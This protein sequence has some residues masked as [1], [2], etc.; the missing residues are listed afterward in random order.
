MKNVFDIV[1]LVTLLALAAAVLRAAGKVPAGALA[2]L[3]TL[4]Q[5]LDLVALPIQPQFMRVC[6]VESNM[7]RLQ[8]ISLSFCAALFSSNLVYGQSAEIASAC[9]SVY[10]GATRNLDIN[11]R[12]QSELRNFYSQHCETNGEVKSSSANLDFDVVIKAIPFKIGGSGSSSKEKFQDFCKTNQEFATSQSSELNFS[13]RVV[14]D[15]LLSFNQCLNIAAQSGQRLIITHTEQPPSSVII[16]GRWKDSVTEGVSLQAI[17]YEEDKVKCFSKSFTTDGSEEEIAKNS[18]EKK[19]LK[20]FS[21]RCDRVGIDANGKRKFERAVIGLSTT[22]G[23]YDVSLSEDAQL[24]FA[25]ASEVEVKF[26]QLEQEKNA[27]VGSLQSTAAEL[28]SLKEKY[29]RKEDYSV[30]LY[31]GNNLGFFSSLWSVNPRLFEQTNC[32]KNDEMLQKGLKNAC[33]EGFTPRDI[34]VF[35]DFTGGPCGNTFREIRCE[36]R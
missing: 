10:D 23:S 32:P 18:A 19:L 11:Y 2:C 22:I 33:Q 7:K 8:T 6:N 5:L 29:E 12:Q 13:N 31:H 1:G 28:Q 17:A 30:I 34:G 35:W 36:R 16:S 3:P 26:A 20:N 9:T 24:G 25:L 27:L 21:I 4:R 15:A 14:T